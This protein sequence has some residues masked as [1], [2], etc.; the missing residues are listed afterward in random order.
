ML[1]VVVVHRRTVDTTQDPLFQPLKVGNL[2]IKHRIVYAPLTRCRAFNGIPSE[3]AQEYYAQRAT[4]GGLM[5]SEGTLVSDKAHGYPCTPGVYT[6]E[7]VEAWKPIIKG[8]HD[9]GAFIF[10]QL[11][12]CG[13]ASHQHYQPNEE[14]PVSS[15]AV[16]I[17]DGSQAFSLKTM[18][19]EDYPVPRALEAEELPAIVD[20]FRQ[21]ARN[22]IEAGFDGVEIH[23]ANGYLL[24]QFMKDG[25]NKRIDPYGGSI[26]NR[27][28]FP[29]EVLDAVVKEIGA[30]RVGY[31]LSPFGGFLSA[32]DSKPY[33]SVTYMI[34][35]MNKYNLAY[36]HMVEPR[37]TGN[38]DVE[39]DPDKTLMPFRNVCKTVFI[40][41]GGYEG[42]SARQSLNE[43]RCDA[44]AFGRRFL[45]NPDFVHRVKIGA[46]LNEYDRSTFYSQGPEGYIDYPTLE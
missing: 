45:A 36:V 9:R 18:K 40:A 11:W 15:S 43:K 14:L 1:H 37:V 23:G 31:R 30:E 19:M 12:H 2:E 38:T 46:P 28:K 10:C 8:V 22:A 24:D 7:Q 3:M 4:E 21:A 27:C 42:S 29:L 17:N 44:V 6:K 13:R 33:A 25:I 41:A 20:E 26:E 16:A 39:E 35:E 34:E 5:I 32:E